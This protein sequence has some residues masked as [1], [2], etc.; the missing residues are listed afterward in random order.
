V[1]VLADG[2]GRFGLDVGGEAEGGVALAL[3]ELEVAEAAGPDDE[4][5]CCSGS[6]RAV[7]RWVKESARTRDGN[8]ADHPALEAGRVGRFPAAGVSNGERT[9]NIDH[10]RRSISTKR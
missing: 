5:G 7:R 3:A 4:P 10:T 8:G 9:M 6:A 2:R 1:A